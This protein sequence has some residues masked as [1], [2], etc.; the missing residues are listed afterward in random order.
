MAVEDLKS[1]GKIAGGDGCQNVAMLLEGPLGV[2]WLYGEMSPQGRNLSQGD[3]VSLWQQGIVAGLEENFVE[4]S[5]GNTAT[6]YKRAASALNM[7][8]SA[9]SMQMRALESELNTTLF[10]RLRTACPKCEGSRVAWTC[11]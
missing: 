8:P 6:R 4:S 11:T 5:V 2:Q 1:G 9:V 3:R 10:N 7:T